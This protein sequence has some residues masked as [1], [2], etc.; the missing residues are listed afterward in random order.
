M[1][2]PTL[3]FKVVALPAADEA[4]ALHVIVNLPLSKHKTQIPVVPAISQNYGRYVRY[5]YHPSVLSIRSLVYSHDHKKQTILTECVLFFRSGIHIFL[6]CI[7]KYHYQKTC[8]PLMKI[9]E[10]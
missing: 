2:Y 5:W 3:S 7:L 9:N 6:C 4:V 8:L 1:T 10:M